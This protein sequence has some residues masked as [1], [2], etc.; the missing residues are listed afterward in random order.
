MANWRTPDW[1]TFDEAFTEDQQTIWKSIFAQCA[2]REFIGWSFKANGVSKTQPGVTSHDELGFETISRQQGFII[3]ERINDPSEL[4]NYQT[5]WRMKIRCSFGEHDYDLRVRSF[6]HE[7]ES[8][9]T[10][11]VRC[12]EDILD[13]VSHDER[14]KL[15]G[16]R[17]TEEEV[18]DRA[19]YAEYA[20]FCD[21]L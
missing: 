16:G 1:E 8:V 15:I 11:W 18:I 17:F 14:R 4:N 12:F 19:H 2:Y 10:Q 13:I 7:P 9:T 6:G 5:F 20:K 21:E 3:L